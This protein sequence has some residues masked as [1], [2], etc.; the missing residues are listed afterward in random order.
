MIRAFQSYSEL[1]FGYFVIS[2]DELHYL[3]H[4]FIGSFR[5]DFSLFMEMALEFP[6][7]DLNHLSMVSLS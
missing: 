1:I 2:D 7:M 4:L 6:L 5:Q 3:G